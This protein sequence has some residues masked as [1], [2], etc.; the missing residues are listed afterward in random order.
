MNGDS[1]GLKVKGWSDTFHKIQCEC[2]RETVSTSWTSST[3]PFFA[4]DGVKR[5][6]M[7]LAE[8]IFGRNVIVLVGISFKGFWNITMLCLKFLKPSSSEYLLVSGCHVRHSRPLSPKKIF[9]LCRGEITV[10]SD[11]VCDIQH[12]LGQTF[13]TVLIE[14]ECGL[15][16]RAYVLVGVSHHHMVVGH[17]HEVVGLA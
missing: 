10:N 7:I 5:L 15:N 16:K 14:F 11:F 17:T 9:H 4:N 12:G 8:H 13:M 2:I 6:R 1:D 3:N